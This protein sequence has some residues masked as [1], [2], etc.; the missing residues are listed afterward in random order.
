MLPDLYR[1]IHEHGFLWVK[2]KA[3]DERQSQVM[4]RFFM[5]AMVMS[6]DFPMVIADIDRD[7]IYPPFLNKPF[8]L[9]FSMEGGGHIGCL[10]VAKKT[11]RGFSCNVHYAMYLKHKGKEGIY[12]PFSAAFW[13]FN[14]DD[15]SA[16]TYGGY[17]WVKIHEDMHLWHW[18]SISN[19]ANAF[20]FMNIKN[21]RL[22]E[23][24]ST[25]RTFGSRSES[26]VKKNFYELVQVKPNI[27]LGKFIKESD[28]I[29]YEHTS[30]R[31]H[32][33]KS[34]IA[35]YEHGLFNNPNLIG[36]F[37]FTSHLR[38]NKENGHIDKSYKFKQN[39]D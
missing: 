8:W 20:A 19:I 28:G 5:D 37:R 36:T 34:R 39:T 26:K 13:E 24:K 9:E 17:E 3:M 16:G 2:D 32:W 12:F 35:F 1:R 29:E 10:I 27:S 21:I 6:G 11:E 23:K 33:V 38:G 7:L 22:L 31:E 30:I 4:S 14:T 18:I 25:I 15:Q